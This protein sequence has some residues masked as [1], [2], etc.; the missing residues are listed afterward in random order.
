M[1]SSKETKI[2]GDKRASVQKDPIR[3]KDERKKKTEKEDNQTSVNQTA[4][5]CEWTLDRPSS[6]LATSTPA[7]VTDTKGRPAKRSLR[8]KLSRVSIT[9][10]R[11]NKTSVDNPT[12]T[13]TDTGPAPQQ[14]LATV[15]QCDQCDFTTAHKSSQ[16]RHIRLHKTKPFQCDTCLKRFEDKHL[17]ELHRPIH[18]NSCVNCLKVFSADTLQDHQRECKRKSYE[19]YACKYKTLKFAH[20]KKHM[21]RMHF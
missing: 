4:N 6:P 11:K 13:T 15:F 3:K 21:Y 20:L 5:Q 2:R 17:L 18:I 8:I 12:E 16:Y 14:R 9:P 7:V 19:C 1:S 10:G